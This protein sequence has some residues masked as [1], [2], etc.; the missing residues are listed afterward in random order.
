MEKSLNPFAAE[1]AG[2]WLTGG[3]VIAPV[4]RDGKL[5]VTPEAW[6]QKDFEEIYDYF[7]QHP[8]HEYQVMLPEGQI[9]V[10]ARDS[11]SERQ[12]RA[13]LKNIGLVPKFSFGIETDESSINTAI[14]Q[15][16]A[17][18]DLETVKT[19]LGQ[20]V[21]VVMPMLTYLPSEKTVHIPEIA[22]ET[23][24]LETEE[25]GPAVS[26]PPT[27]FD[28][29]SL[30]GSEEEMAR[31]AIVTVALLGA[32]ILMGQFGLIYAQPNTGKTLVTIAL[33]IQAVEDGRLNPSF[34]YYVNADDNAE[35]IV[36]KLDIFSEMGAHT[37]VPGQ[38]GFDPDKLIDLMQTMIKNGQC[39][40]VVLILDTLKCFIDLMDKKRS[41]QF[42]KVVRQFV[43]AGGTFVGLA[44]TNKNPGTNGK[45]VYAGTSDFY[46]A[47]DAA[48]YLI[49]VETTAKG[50]KIVKFEL[51]KKRGGGNRDE[52][53]SYS[54]SND[55]SYAQLVAS[56]QPIDPEQMHKYEQ[57]AQLVADQLVIDTI[58]AVLKQGTKQKMALA[59]DVSAT[60]KASR[61]QVI[62]VLE[63]YAGDD[64]TKRKWDFV[65]AERG[66]KVFALHPTPDS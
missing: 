54:G 25:P 8:G 40:G 17:S 36:A 18:V 42:A 13:T 3:V 12:S 63:R 9:I 7:V 49:P 5:L 64:P 43:V 53:Y 57:A 29:Y 61:R 60:T 16:D 32:V 34:L 66:A 58:I 45:P 55:V 39:V 1:Y 35:G 52:A 11:H 30:L 37:L 44:H 62:E 23:S 14:H 10:L 28:K 4:D 24:S 20:N 59:K 21:E 26:V 15:A 6:A 41:T 50:D 33:L 27:P 19:R 65:V 48:C 51:F 56:V 31:F 38:K 47:C 46:E 22:E 2:K